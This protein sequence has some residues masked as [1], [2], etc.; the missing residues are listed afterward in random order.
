VA[1]N[2]TL[3]EVVISIAGKKHWLWRAVDQEASFSMSWSK[4]DATRRR[5]AQL[6]IE[7]LRMH[8]SIQALALLLLAVG[9]LVLLHWAT[10]WR[11]AAELASVAYIGLIA[12]VAQITGAA[13][14]MFPELG[15]LAHEIFGRPGGRWAQS[16]ILLILTPVLTAAIG[17][18]ITR[19]LSYGL[20]SVLLS[21]G[22][23]L[24]VIRALKSPVA[25]AISAGLLPLVLGV[26]SWWY[27]PAILFGTSLLAGLAVSRARLFMRSEPPVPPQPA[28]AC[29]P[30]ATLR[31][32]E[33]LWVPWF[34]LFLLVTYGCV[35]L[36]GWRFLLYPP[37]VV[38]G[39][40]MLAHT[41]RCP[42][43]ENPLLVPLVCFLTAAGGMVFFTVFGPGLLAAAVSM[44]CGAAILRA[45]DL[46]V[47]PALAVGLLPLVI[48]R[49][50]LWYPVA[51][52]LG[53]SILTVC[54][55]LHQ[56]VSARFG[57]APSLRATSVVS[58]GE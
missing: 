54:F 9:I 15:A 19:N 8:H 43:S 44:A 36:T 22:C 18:V 25:P 20:A 38:I 41:D 52:A 34:V 35:A 50:T 49:P 29:R 27:P 3:D 6:D 7:G 14:I 1:T 10:R 55:L 32:L 58:A 5:P 46:H 51:I 31:L 13:Y 4:A 24:V 42:W 12:S 2:G 45:F 26:T 48:D 40:E 57:V 33:Y 47:P 56:R 17:T 11:M 37:L 53:T 39:F 30:E 16:P 23:A 21:I 28:D